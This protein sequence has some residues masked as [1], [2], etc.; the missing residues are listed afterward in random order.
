MLPTFTADQITEALKRARGGFDALLYSFDLPLA[1]EQPGRLKQR[2]FPLV[3]VYTI[4][5][6]YELIDLSGRRDEACRALGRFMYWDKIDADDAVREFHGKPKLTA[7]ERIEARKELAA[8]YAVDPGLVHDCFKPCEPQTPWFL[9]GYPSP[10][11]GKMRLT[12]M[13]DDAMWMTTTLGIR[14]A[15]VVN[16]TRLITDVDAALAAVTED[17]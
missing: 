8:K 4:A 9:V 13:Q 10:E 3:D 6:A 12:P 1:S 11:D 2:H 16:M 5:I 14:T 17:A 7:A 15:W